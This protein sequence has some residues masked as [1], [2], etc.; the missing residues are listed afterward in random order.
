M[1]LKNERILFPKNLYDAHQRTIKLI[2]MR[3]DKELDKKI[4][5]RFKDIQ[6]RF[7]F[8]YQG[9]M[10]RPINSH[11]ELIAE[12]KH[13]QHCVASY[14]KSL[15]EGK[16]TILVIRKINR[17]NTPYYTM[18]IWNDQIIQVRGLKNCN[19]NEEVKKLVDSFK[20]KKLKA[21]KKAKEKIPA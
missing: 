15:A 16:T 12:G 6:K 5:A 18:E 17:P 19:P 9:L 3:E 21:S 11:K 4:M 20:A 13:L 7:S 8:E 14:A 1:D 10:V 2:K